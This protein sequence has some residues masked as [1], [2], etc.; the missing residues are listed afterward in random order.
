[1]IEIK[2]VSKN[3]NDF[4]VLKDIN[5]VINEENIFGIIG[6]SGAGK[7]SL[8]RMIN[9]LIKPDF[10]EVLVDG[11]NITACD[12]KSL[13]AKREDIGMI[14][15]QYNLLYQSSVLDNVMLGL[16]NKRMPK[17][18]K[19]AVAKEML[20]L[21]G[22][23]DKIYSYPKMLSGGQMQRVSIARALSKKPKYLLCDEITSSLDQKTS[24]QILDLL[25][26][27]NQTLKVSI[28]FVS[29]DIDAVKYVCSHVCVIKDKAITEIGLIKEL[30]MNHQSNISK[31]FLNHF[32]DKLLLGIEGPVYELYFYND[33]RTPLISQISK[34]H[35]VDIDIIHAKTSEIGG[36]QIGF[37]LITIKG[38]NINEAIIDLKKEAKV[39]LYV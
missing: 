13:R 37:M 28:V 19:E 14:F 8:I 7:S 23:E 31:Q 15:Q 34:K 39:N 1:M 21:V 38:P 35:D 11:L 16:K 18:Q 3:F 22:L 25:K 30:A 10:G 9:G 33:V 32:D 2:N 20:Q 29:H 12:D 27:I 17:H 24:Y 6:Q 36:T 26:V 5:L 4:E